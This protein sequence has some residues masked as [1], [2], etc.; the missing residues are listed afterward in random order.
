MLRADLA[1]AR[2][3]WLN[4][5][6]SEAGKQERERSDFQLYADHRGHVSDFHSLRVLYISG[7]VT[8]GASVKVA[9][10]LARHSTPEL[11]FNVYACAG[12]HDVAGA[13]EGLDDLQ[14]RKPARPEA[15]PMRATG[16]DGR[17]NPTRLD[18]HT[19]V[20][21]RPARAG[22]NR[23]SAALSVPFGPD[24]PRGLDG[25]QRPQKHGRIKTEGTGFEP[26]THCWASD[27]ESDR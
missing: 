17:A 16:T 18:V 8:R 22:S 15:E 23:H 3:D 26:A 7:V 14:I 2:A 1:A 21:T 9:Q 4:G 10:S 5:A 25:R 19:D 20:H 12:L 11:T 24:D 13:V 6:D 27:F